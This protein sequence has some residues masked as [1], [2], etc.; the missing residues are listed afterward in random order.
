MG[1]ETTFALPQA[2]EIRIALDINCSV[3]VNRLLT[4]ATTRPVQS[5]TGAGDI[6]LALKYA[7][8]LA[9]ITPEDKDLARLIQDLQR[10]GN[11][12]VAR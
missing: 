4:T 8:Q 1:T 7:E 6:D 3:V 5:S 12:P 11:K 9:P 2:V 10:H